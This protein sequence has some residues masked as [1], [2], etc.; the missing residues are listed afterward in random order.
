MSSSCFSPTVLHD[1]NI[2]RS[3]LP[4]TF[5]GAMFVNI[6]THRCIESGRLAG[7]AY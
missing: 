5:N 1:S 7:K 6:G 2:R 4:D 3:L